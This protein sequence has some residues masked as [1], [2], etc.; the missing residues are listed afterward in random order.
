MAPR[1]ISRTS[2]LPYPINGVGRLDAQRLYRHMGIMCLPIHSP[3]VVLPEL[4]TSVL[5]RQV[6]PQVFLMKWLPR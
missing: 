4:F 6:R 2:I 5:E 3:T 1:L